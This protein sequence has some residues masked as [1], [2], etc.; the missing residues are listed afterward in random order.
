MSHND[1]T[2]SAAQQTGP[3]FHFGPHISTSCFLTSSSG[4][5][6]SPLS[7][8]GDSG[9]NQPAFPQLPRI[10]HRPA[11]CIGV[12]GPLEAKVVVNSHVIAAECQRR[13]IAA[14]LKAPSQETRSYRV[15]FTQ[16][17]YGE[18]YALKCNKYGI[19]EPVSSDLIVVRSNEVEHHCQ[20]AV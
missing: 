5:S 6:A 3:V 18:C 15:T 10:E 14:G 12:K 16:N 17:K 9:P 19:W 20:T 11:S 13:P 7:G 1:R 8:H 2:C 4:S